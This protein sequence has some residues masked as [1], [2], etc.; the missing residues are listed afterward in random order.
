MEEHPER[1]DHR[2]RRRHVRSPHRQEGGEASSTR[3]SPTTNSSP[4]RPAPVG[5]GDAFVLSIANKVERDDPLER[6]LPGV[7]RRVHVAVRRG[8]PDRRQA[9]AARRLGVRRSA[10]GARPGQPQGDAEAKRKAAGARQPT[11]AQVRAGSD[12][13]SQPMPVPKTP[14]PGRDAAQAGGR[15]RDRRGGR[16]V[17]T[18]RRQP[19]RRP[20]QTARAAPQ[21][22]TRRQRPDAV[23]RVRRAPPVGHAA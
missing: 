11:R 9:G 15:G 16:A 20:R 2:R 22:S 21:A 23:P 8:P 6:L 19:P 14:P 1:A 5:R 18:S 10:A 13:A 17:A 4:R 7:P 12:A 3:P